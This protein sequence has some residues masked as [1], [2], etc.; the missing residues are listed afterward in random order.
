L[1]ARHHRVRAVGALLAVLACA[2]CTGGGGAGAGAGGVAST[3]GSPTGIAGHG[4]ADP[5]IAAAGDIACQP[6]GR[7]T[8][9]S[10]QQRATSDLLVRQPLAAV[11][12]LGDEQYD[13]GRIKSFR[14]QY[15]PTWGRELSITYPAPGNHE[16]QSGGDG[17]YEYFG[18]RAGEPSRP[19]YSFDIGAWHIIALDSECGFAGGCQKGSPQERWLVADLRA[20]PTRCVLAF[21]HEPR[22]SSGGHG[23]NRAYVPFWED[24]YAAHAD[25]VLNG[26]DH[27]Y[28][29]FAPQTPRAMAS[30]N[31]IREFVVGTGGKSLRRFHTVKANSQ[32]R[33]ATFGVL[34]LRLHPTSYDWRF[35]PIA[36][37]SFT[38][39]GSA[40]CD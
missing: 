34:E 22:F 24:L 5:L 30:A 33:S 4:S 15:G 25:V 37:S 17:Y 7:V 20:H 32:V 11:L 12:T 35:V 18:A 39:S 27:D 40:R 6:G 19:Y 23:N 9:T 21:W 38:D 26:H 16:Y 2:G 10:C 13:Q 31:G 3:P 8:P 1:R 14:T 29:R 36:G 28:E